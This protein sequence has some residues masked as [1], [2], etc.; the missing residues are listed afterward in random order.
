[1]QFSISYTTKKKMYAAVLI[2][3]AASAAL[4][5]Y[6]I[7]FEDFANITLLITCGLL[8]GGTFFVLAL[9]FIPTRWDS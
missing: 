5:Y 4:F 2:Y 6:G 9:R 1:M 3:Y 7:A 8:L